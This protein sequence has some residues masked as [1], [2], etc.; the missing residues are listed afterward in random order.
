MSS[1]FV[2]ETTGEAIGFPLSPRYVVVSRNQYV[3]VGNKY[4]SGCEL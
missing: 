4:R 1:L 2:G 3:S